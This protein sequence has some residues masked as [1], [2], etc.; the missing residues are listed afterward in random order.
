MYPHIVF[1]QLKV[2][3][4]HEAW[5]NFEFSLPKSKPYS[6]MPLV[7]PDSLSPD[8]RIMSGLWYAPMIFLLSLSDR[9]DLTL[10]HYD[11]RIQSQCTVWWKCA[12]TH[13]QRKAPSYQR[14]VLSNRNAESLITNNVHKFAF[15]Y[16]L[17][18]FCILY[19]CKSVLGLQIR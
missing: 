14:S 4:H 18:S 7:N 9:L 6:Y 2:H 13:Y 11:I 16:Y 5:D 8:R 3:K 10:G 15:V 1:A 12:E 17:C 19:W